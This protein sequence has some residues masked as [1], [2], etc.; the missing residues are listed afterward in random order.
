MQKIL[1]SR[2]YLIVELD[3]PHVQKGLRTI[4]TMLGGKGLK[5]IKTKIEFF[6]SIDF[7][8]YKSFTH[9]LFLEYNFNPRASKPAYIW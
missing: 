6:F 3:F 5:L 2:Y 7:D 1:G 4:V 8:I 9:L